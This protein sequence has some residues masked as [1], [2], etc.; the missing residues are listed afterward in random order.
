MSAVGWQRHGG[1]VPAPAQHLITS[2]RGESSPQG[3][4]L[5]RAGSA[6][7]Q[8]QHS[9]ERGLHLAWEHS[10]AGYEGVGAGDTAPRA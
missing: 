5:G 8:L 1:N 7:H 4:E 6:P 10:G 9:G 2:G 3:H